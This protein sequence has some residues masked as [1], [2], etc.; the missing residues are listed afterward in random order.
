MCIARPFYYPGRDGILPLRSRPDRVRRVGMRSKVLAHSLEKTIAP[1]ALIAQL[2]VVMPAVAIVV[3]RHDG[4]AGQNQSRDECGFN[5]EG[6]SL[7]PPSCLNE[8]FPCGKR[9]TAAPS[10][11]H[12]LD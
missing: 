11:A 8:V 5:K 1:V 7:E 3:L 10:A 6:V 12:V 2:P 4:Q 9:F